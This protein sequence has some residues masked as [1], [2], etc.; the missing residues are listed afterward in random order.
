MIR[1]IAPVLLLNFVNIISFSIFI[2]ILPAIVEAYGSTYFAYGVLLSVFSLAQFFAAPI[3][4]SW[5]D[6]YGRRKV[7]ILSQAGTLLSWIIFGLAWFLP[8]ARIGIISIPLAV[9]FI[10]RVIDGLTGGN[11]TVAAAYVA[12]VVEPKEK[13]KAFGIFGAMVGIGFL[14]GP[15]IGGISYGT[16]ITY[17]GTALVASF[18]SI[19]T[20]YSIV[21]WLPESLPPEKRTKKVK[22]SILSELN[23]IN[24]IQKFKFNWQTQKLFIIRIFFALGFNAYTSIIVLFLYKN[25]PIQPEEVGLVM[26]I[27]GV[28]AFFNQAFLVGKISE[29]IGEKN[30]YYLGYIVLLL[31]LPILTLK[32]GILTF[33]MFSYFISL[34]IDCVMPTFKTIISNE[35][36]DE[37]QGEALGIDEALGSVGRIIS[38]LIF[39]LLYS[40]LEDLTFLIISAMLISP[41][42]IFF[43]HKKTKQVLKRT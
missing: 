10:S 41:F 21:K 13:T 8:D 30:T 38:P 28:Y 16:S 14:F 19:I 31:A 22:S 23:I 37:E 33:L 40:Q 6:H 20:L 7:L 2:P 34:S 27:V 29:K 12:D 26:F 5:S 18:I 42:L 4:G 1:K 43:F 11:I 9:I 3:L 17:L 39:T 15:S 25:Y 24:R 36:K 32:M 35:V